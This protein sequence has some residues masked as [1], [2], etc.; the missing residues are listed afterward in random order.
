MGQVY[1]N[2]GVVFD[3]SSG[4]LL[5]DIQTSVACAAPGFFYYTAGNKIVGIS[6]SGLIATEAVKDRKG[7][8]T[9]KTTLADPSW[10]VEVEGAPIV[11]MIGAGDA[12]IVGRE[13]GTVQVLSTP[14]KK[15]S[16][17]G[18]VEGK[19]L[20][21][22]VA[23]GALFVGAD[24]GSLFSFSATPN[25]SPKKHEAG[26]S[27][28]PYGTNETY[29][30]AASEILERTGVREGYCVDLACGEGA[31]AYELAK[32]SGLKIFALDE[33]PA[34]VAQAR[35]NLMAAGL[36]G[37][38][39]TVA[40]GDPSS[41]WY[42]NYFANLVVSGRSVE[43]GPDTF[44]TAEAE[45]LTRPYG[46]VRYYGKPD[47]LA[48]E[49]RGPMEGAGNW[50]HQYADPANTI[51]SDDQL[52]GGKLGMLWFRDA[53]QEMPQRHGRGPAPLFYEGRLI[54]EG[55]HGLRAIDAYN[56]RTLWNFELPDIL[57]SYDQDHLVGAAVTGSNFCVGDGFVFARTR[58]R[59]LK[60]D[61]ETGKSV[62]EFDTPY[63]PDPGKGRNWGFIA[64]VDG[65]LYGS[66]ADTAHIVQKAFRDSDMS[67]LFS[68]SHYFFAMDPKSGKLVWDFK[69]QHSIRNNTIAIG[70]E[71]VFLIDRPLAEVD[72]F[73]AGQAARRGQEKK[74]EA[75][76]AP[77]HGKGTLY[78]LDAKTGKVLWESEEDIFG[79]MLALSRDHDVLVMSYQFTRFK[80]NSETGDR[81]AAFRAS[82][83]SRIWDI[84]VERPEGYRSSSRPILNG[85]TV[86][87][88]PGAYDLLTGEKTEFSM[89]RSYG[90]GIVT[91]SKN[92]M[93]FRSATLGYL[94]IADAECGTENYGGLRPGCWI[95]AIPA[96]GLVLM[97]DASAGCTCSY[98]NRASI[99]LQP[100]EVR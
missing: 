60:I 4:E 6:R 34:N 81:L 53:D 57:T 75:K 82:D 33:D 92:L 15:V 70:N 63:G 48:M 2:N 5:K 42:P 56:G 72:S 77:V 50:T 24:N 25:D 37:T 80:Q 84:P 41:T 30:R 8:E 79:T 95:N 39:V 22:A 21:L 13:D 38:R 62:A 14:E 86:Y 90:C 12:L 71:K 47:A 98:L 64:Y 58:Y 43:E 99:A 91:S 17:T 51:C 1:F 66:T 9:T 54:V 19:P 97:P 32:Q 55:M 11:S 36:Y 29:R 85:Q 96:G 76:P 73:E 59:C 68:E 23:E 69:P 83:G 61:V 20:A 3:A 44:P 89:N 78:A 52:V 28:E 10:E 45:R 46:G 88:E 26:I 40:Q 87:L 100:F 67:E 49:V 7:E 74:E 94:N 93:L 18:K 31:L 16:W 27:D 35:A 65:L